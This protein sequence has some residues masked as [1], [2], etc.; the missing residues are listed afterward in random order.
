MHIGHVHL[1]VADLGEAARFYSDLLG[2]SVTESIGDEFVFMSGGGAHHELA[3]QQAADLR[4]PLPGA[5]GLYHTAF[6]ASD[7]N[8]FKAKIRKMRELNLNFSIV[9]H[10]ISWAA[11]T[12]DPSTNGVEIYLD[13][14]SHRD[15]SKKW[16]G[17]SKLLRPQEVLEA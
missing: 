14:R 6:E 11:Y 9:D 13:R 16:H 7:L 1:K 2:F 15:G 3:L 17:K 8:E 5:V 10:G 12:E 4:P